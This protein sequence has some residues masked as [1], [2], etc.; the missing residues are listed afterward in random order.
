MCN[1]FQRLSFPLVGNRSDAPFGKKILH[2][3]FKRGWKDSGQAGMTDMNK[4]DQ[5]TLKKL[6]VS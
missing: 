2:T 5:T 3:P 4:V 1:L 6:T